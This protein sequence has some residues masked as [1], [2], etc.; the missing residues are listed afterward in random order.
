MTPK[1]PKCSDLHAKLQKKFRVIGQVAGPGL[2]KAR[3]LEKVL[4]F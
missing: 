4:S 2:E 3:F 1:V